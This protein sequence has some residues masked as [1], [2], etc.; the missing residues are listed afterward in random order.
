MVY[1]KAIAQSAAAIPFDRAQVGEGGALAQ[2]EHRV[3]CAWQELNRLFER[4]EGQRRSLVQDFHGRG[5]GL[6]GA[7]RHQDDEQHDRNLWDVR[8]PHYTD[9]WDRADHVVRTI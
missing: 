5:R 4:T 6:A 7:T 9:T 3:L 8:L 1:P 2:D